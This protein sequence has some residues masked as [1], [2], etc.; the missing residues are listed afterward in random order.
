[1]RNLALASLLFLAG[2]V[3]ALAQGPY[4]GTYILE[5]DDGVSLTLREDAGGGL[6]GV[7]LGNGARYEVT[8]VGRGNR[9]VGTMQGAEARLGFAGGLAADSLQLRLFEVDAAGQPLPG[10]EEQ[11]VFVLRGGTV[12]INGQVL[13]AETIATLES[14]YRVQIQGG[15]YWYD[16]AC[17]AWGL[18]G[19]P[20]AGFILPGLAL[21]GA[22]RADASGGGTGVFFNGRELHR[23]DALA[24]QQLFGVVI[25]GRYTLDAYGNLALENGRFVVNLLQAVR[26]SQGGG[27]SIYRSNITGIGAGGSGGTSYVMGKD[28][29]VIIGD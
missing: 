21:G 17:G 9:I 2:G 11:H 22:L 27:N 16:A 20:T 8:G 4:S 5:G 12:V 1:M 19:G 29:S 15:R 10:T 18:E 13:D 3:W 25:P 14:G 23:Q 6:S 7:L 26:Q 24:L 28:W